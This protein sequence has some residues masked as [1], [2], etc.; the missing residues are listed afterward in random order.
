MDTDYEIEIAAG[1]ERMNW[2]IIY[3]I[4]V[5]GT[6]QE[7]TDVVHS[8]SLYNFLSFL[9]SVRARCVLCVCV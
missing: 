3:K 4:F 9:V 5:S 2:K 6:G 1:M 8:Q 7:Q